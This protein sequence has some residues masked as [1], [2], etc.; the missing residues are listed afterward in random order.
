[1]V[2]GAN[3][4]IGKLAALG[5]AEMGGSVHMLCRN[6]ERGGKEHKHAMQPCFLG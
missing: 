3:S 6:P 1:M 2:T 5:L 4:G